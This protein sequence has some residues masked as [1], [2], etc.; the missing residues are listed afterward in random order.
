MTNRLF[1]LIRKIVYPSSKKEDARTMHKMNLDAQISRDIGLRDASLSGW[2]QNEK[3]EIFTGVPIGERDIVVDVGCGEGGVLS[4]CANRGA[5]IIGVEIDEGALDSAKSKIAASKS[6]KCEFHLANAENLPLSAGLATRVI[7]TEVLEHVED[8]MIV[9]KELYRIGAP[10]ALYLITVPDSLQENM[11][12]HVADD[13]YFK[14]PNHIRIIDRHEFPKMI[15]SAGLEVISQTGYGFYWG[16][17]WAMFWGC[18]CEFKSAEHRALLHWAM[19]WNE[20]IKTEKGRRIKKG[21]DD[22]LP[23]SQVIVARKVV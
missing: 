7:C 10:D 9:L 5:H 22:F 23:K 17:W 4:F 11:Q 2:F 8:P 14:H 6:V 19:A 13:I 1:S 16:I 3:N 21:L 12:K 20:L 18:E 15:E